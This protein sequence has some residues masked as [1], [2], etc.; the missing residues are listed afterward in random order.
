MKTKYVKL[1]P[2]KPILGLKI[3][4][5]NPVEKIEL[6]IEEI[7]ICICDKC[8]VDEYLNDGT[9][10]RLNLSNYMIDNNELS[11][12]VEELEITDV[13][14]DHVEEVK[15]DDTQKNKE[16]SITVKETVNTTKGSKKHGGKK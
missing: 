10:K 9:L 7:R 1:H 14:E 6:A 4:I 5:S 11:H 8:I 3:P 16:E 2:M 12:D 15:I 13:E